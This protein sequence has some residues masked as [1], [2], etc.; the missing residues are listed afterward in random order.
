M[1][2]TKL[3]LRAGSRGAVVE[4]PI[5]NLEVAGSNPEVGN[6]FSE[7]YLEN[8]GCEERERETEN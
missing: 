2:N 6:I 1:N 4:R 5:H 8:W 7:R 3:F